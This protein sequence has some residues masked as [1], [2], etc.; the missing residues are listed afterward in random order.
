MNGQAVIADLPICESS[1]QFALTP[2][3]SVFIAVDPT[4]LQ[5]APQVRA[6]PQQVLVL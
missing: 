4:Q 2:L 6:R 1:G 3:G 5:A